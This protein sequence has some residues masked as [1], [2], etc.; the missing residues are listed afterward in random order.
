MLGRT[1]LCAMAVILLAAV[2]CKEMERAMPQEMPKGL[3]LY[4]AT[5]GNDAWSGR[6]A[7]PNAGKSDG[8]FATMGRARDEIRKIRMSGTP[9]ETRN[10]VSDRNLV[11]SALPVGGVTVSVRGGVY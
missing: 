9:P 10:Q 3:I 4:V 6:L 11:S 8:P 5:N 2:G 7:E 1:G